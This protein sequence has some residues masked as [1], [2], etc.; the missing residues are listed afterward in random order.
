MGVISS[1]R[2]QQGPCALNASN[3]NLKTRRHYDNYYHDDHEDPELGPRLGQGTLLFWVAP[4]VVRTCR[5]DFWYDK[6]SAAGPG[7]KLRLV[8]W[9]CESL[10]REEHQARRTSSKHHRRNR[11]LSTGLSKL[12]AYLHRFRSFEFRMGCPTISGILPSIQ[13]ADPLRVQGM[14]F[15]PCS[16]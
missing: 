11:P 9:T 4:G 12:K 8:F 15:A 16:S 3:S 6:R 13:K 1:S 5:L 7:S 2:I 14:R 10:P